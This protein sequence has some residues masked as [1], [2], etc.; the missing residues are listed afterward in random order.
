M[1]KMYTK[2][3]IVL[4]FCVTVSTVWGSFII[5]STQ[6]KNGVLNVALVMRGKFV[7]NSFNIT[8]EPEFRIF[9][10]QTLVP[11]Y[12]LEPLTAKFLFNLT[13]SFL[14]VTVGFNIFPTQIIALCNESNEN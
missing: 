6:N 2:Y 7:D 4:L 9:R 3:L 5:Q 12:E 14:N 13:G 11:N 1:S 10:N 8:L